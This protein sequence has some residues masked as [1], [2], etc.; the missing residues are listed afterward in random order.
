MAERQSAIFKSTAVL[1]ILFLSIF[2]DV[3]L[4]F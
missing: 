2:I 4:A 3:L 1:N